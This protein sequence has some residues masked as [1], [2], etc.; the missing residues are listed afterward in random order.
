MSLG[1]ADAWRVWI[2]ELASRDPRARRFG[3]R[4]HGYR[5]APPLGEDGVR[6]VEQALA[7][8]LPDDH[9]A[10]LATIA[11]GGAGPYHGLLPVDH[12][13]QRRCAAGTFELTAPTHEADGDLD[14]DGDVAASDASAA[15][16]ARA[17]S[18][19]GAAHDEARATRVD[20]VY[21]GVL[22]L[23]HVGCG[24]IALLVVRGAAAGQVWLDAREAGLGIAP[25]APSFTA[26]V[27]DWIARST[28]NLLPRAVVPAGVC[29]LPAALSSYLAQ[30]ERDRGLE[31]G[32]I[33]DRGLRDALGAIGPRAIATAMV[34]DRPFFAHGDLVDPCPSCEVMLENLRGRGLGADALTPGWPPIPE[35][36]TGR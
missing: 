23:G 35:R 16:A 28:R 22:G 8:R 21:Q 3:A 11:A 15:S 14:V 20:R 30:R 17:A 18:D 25:I 9:R 36:A 2:A 7:V 31:P 27:Q 6:A 32:T 13:V 24:Y 26:Y 12:P 19:A 4:Q 33:D 29:S 34:S 1:S 10:F 5:V